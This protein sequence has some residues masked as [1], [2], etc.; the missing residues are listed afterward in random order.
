MSA[1][2]ET[3]GKRG[4]L[5]VI[6][7][8]AL[9]AVTAGATLLIERRNHGGDEH[10]GHEHTGEGK[11]EHREHDGDGDHAGEAKPGEPRRLKM[12]EELV[13]NAGLEMA[14]AAPGKVAVTLELP[15]EVALNAERL[16]HVTP[17]IGG[18]VR[19]VNSQLG[20]KV[21]K[22]DVLA[23]LDSKELA[24]MQRDVLATKERLALAE[25]S[26]QRAES[27]WNEKI[28]AEKDFL[29]AKNALA[30]ARI[31]HRS[32]T[33]K[34]A[35]A[36]GTGARGTGLA[37]IAPLDGT[38]IEKHISIGEVLS[39]NTQAFV[40][41]DLSLLWVQVTVYSKDLSR[42]HAGQT[43][44]VVAE[45]IAEPMVGKIAY[46]DRVVGEETRTATAR[47]EIDDPGTAWRPG[48]FVTAEVAIDEIDAA[49]TVADEAV[50]RVDGKE[51]VFV[52]SADGF[53][54]RTVTLGRRGVAGSKER[55]RVVEVLSGVSAGDRYATHNSFVLKAELGKGEA[56]HDH[57]H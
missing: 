7:A 22:G 8:V 35:A 28:S 55:G 42:V 50:Q 57:A 21:H 18:T 24:E 56:G 20:D 29:A 40:I 43:A 39:D 6:G 12:S 5:T 54:V 48:L 41:A 44:R 19:A 32:A 52:R 11:G 30:E 15:G 2:G 3:T 31:E 9:V 49:V 37:L 45:G 27:L 36:A 1:P 34:M 46:I 38:I 13:H 26:F 16:A 33:Q 10:D 14:V 17:R 23:T 53:E 51:V 25:Q 47:V 4:A